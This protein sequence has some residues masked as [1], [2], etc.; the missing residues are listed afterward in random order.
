MDSALQ[1]LQGEVASVN[2]AAGIETGPHE[3]FKACR[4][5]RCA[6]ETLSVSLQVTAKTMTTRKAA[7]V[8]MREGVVMEKGVEVEKGVM[9]GKKGVMKM[10]GAV[11]IVRSRSDGL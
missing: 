7:G 2:A 1:Q 4:V 11:E 5:L 6:F 3:L 8:T 10:M 9:V